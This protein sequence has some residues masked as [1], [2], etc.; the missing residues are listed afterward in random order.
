MKVQGDLHAGYE[1]LLDTQ[2]PNEEAMNDIERS[3][4]QVAP[5]LP[6]GTRS[7]ALTIR[8]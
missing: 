5:V 3:Q 4:R 8:P 7:V 1:I 2:F 6:A